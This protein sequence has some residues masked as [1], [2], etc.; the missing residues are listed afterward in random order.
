LNNFVTINSRKFD[1]S[2]RR[3]WACRLVEQDGPLLV[4]EGVF[5]LDVQHDD[6]GFIRR[7]TVSYEYYWRDRWYNVFRFHEPEGYLRN[8]YCNIN[9]PPVFENGVLDYVDLD[10]D[11]LVWKDFSYRILDREDFE[12][13]AEKYGY[14]EELRNK[15]E[16][17]LKEIT[18]LINTRSF[19][20]GKKYRPAN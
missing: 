16:D 12:E 14:S 3:S 18:E 9:M 19:P 15:V 7:G 8:Y 11:V 17:S 5:D 4:F 13:N 10:L 20:F 6:L 1:G 2:I